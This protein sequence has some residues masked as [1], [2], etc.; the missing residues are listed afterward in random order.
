MASKGDSEAT[1]PDCSTGCPIKWPRFRRGSK[2]PGDARVHSQVS[3]TK[4]EFAGPEF[5]EWQFL[6]SATE[7]NMTMKLVVYWITT[8]FIAFVMAASGVL[9]ISHTPVFM[10]ALSH[11]GYPPYFANLLGVGKLIGVCILLGPGLSKLKE[12][13]YVAFGITVLSACYSHYSAG[14]GWL[15]LE[16][17]VTFAALIISYRTRPENRIFPHLQEENAL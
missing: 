15:A 16:P 6:E 12:W 8:V 7:R 14:D 4:M 9:A 10:K 13:V 3:V 5:C 1:L 17:L 11:L 2:K